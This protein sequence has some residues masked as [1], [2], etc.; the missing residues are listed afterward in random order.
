MAEKLL[1]TRNAPAA[2]TAWTETNTSIRPFGMNWLRFGSGG[3][4]GVD[5]R[6]GLGARGTGRYSGGSDI[7]H[8]L[9]ITPSNVTVAD[10]N[11]PNVN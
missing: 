7:T 6:N 9:T 11:R 4:I 2:R 1:A 10:L 3:G 8:T 5:G